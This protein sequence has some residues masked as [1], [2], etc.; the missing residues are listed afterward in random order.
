MV[1]LGIALLIFKSLRHWHSRQEIRIYRDRIE[2]STKTVG[3]LITLKIDELKCL[4]FDLNDQ[5]LQLRF[6]KHQDFEYMSQLKTKGNQITFG[7]SLEAM[8]IILKSTRVYIAYMNA[9][10]ILRLE[11][12]IQAEVHSRTHR[13]LT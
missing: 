3:E 8:K 7:E 13:H 10:D 5:S 1:P 6:V 4:A 11:A 2:L 9:S 12:L